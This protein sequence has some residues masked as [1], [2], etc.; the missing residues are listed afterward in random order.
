[1]SKYL[2]LITF[3]ALYN[4]KKRMLKYYSPQNQ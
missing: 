1:M 2:Q 3:N 4:A